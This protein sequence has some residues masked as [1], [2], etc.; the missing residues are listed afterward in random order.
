MTKEISMQHTWN[1]LRAVAGC[2]SLS[3]LCSVIPVFQAG[4]SLPSLAASLG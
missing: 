2:S 1:K 4:R 3:Q